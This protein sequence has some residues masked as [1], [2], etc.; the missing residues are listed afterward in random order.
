MYAGR[1]VETAPTD[2]LFRSMRHPY[3]QALLGSIP[4]MDS[5]PRKALVT[6]PGMPPDLTDP[7]FGCRFA[8]RCPYA[9]QQC[10][11]QEPP[12][13]GDDPRHLFACWHPV[14]GPITKRP[15]IP[16][17]AAAL[18]ADS[19]N[20]SRTGGGGNGNAEHLLSVD[21]VI[22]EYPV[23]AGA[24]LQRKVASVKAVSGVTLHLDPGETFGL[25]GE[26]GCGKTTLG[27]LIVGIEKL[28]GGRIAL[29]GQEVFE[30]RGRELRH[31]RR[32]LQM[33][34]QDP[35]ASLDPR[36]RVSTIL[37]EPLVVQRM[38]TASEQRQRIAK[39]LDQV[40]L[41]L[42]ALERYPHEFSGGQRQRIGLARALMLEP[43]VL[44]ADEPVSALDVSIRSQVL[45]LMKRL[46]A[47][48]QMA[49]LVI[50]VMYLGKLVEI[51]SGEDIYLRPAHPY[52]EA[53]IKTIPLPDPAAEKAKTEVGIRGE[54]PSPINPPSGCRFRTRC[55]RAQSIC[56][57]VEPP[58]RAFGEGHRAA[59]HFP[60]QT[61]TEDDGG[62]VT[63]SVA[64]GQPGSGAADQAEP[65]PS[66]SSP[67]SPS[68]A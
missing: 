36:M 43:K 4:K 65:G 41:P 68:A 29:N 55:P 5:D 46:Q 11:E 32:D 9:T 27:K 16:G 38:G 20:G 28:N 17:V 7:P 21:D 14:D 13:T 23:T 18:A 35:Y 40:G 59:C 54:L 6:I 66:G 30:Q 39:M 51:G 61:P 22:R 47:E 8:P 56:S 24:L 2:E 37:R 48:Y 42:N 15:E 50:G 12:L 49:S 1:L 31:S 25:V 64:A 34:F 19:T 45:N 10:R 63:L 26:S 52:T 57:E 58:L 44:V 67:D 60:L 33:M 53:L 62:A 3:T